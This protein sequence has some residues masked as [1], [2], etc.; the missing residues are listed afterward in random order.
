MARQTNSF[1]EEVVQFGKYTAVTAAASLCN[2][3]KGFQ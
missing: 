1:S 3:A 2:R